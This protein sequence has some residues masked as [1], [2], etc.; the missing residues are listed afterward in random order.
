VG[1]LEALEAVAAL[2]LFADDIENRVDEFGALG[3]VPLC[4]V[5]AGARL[6]KYK[7]VRLEELAKGPGSDCKGAV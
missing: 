4:P 6:T 2:G 3:V 7:V 1:D 5:V